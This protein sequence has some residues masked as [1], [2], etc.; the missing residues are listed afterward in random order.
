MNVV[1]KKKY[2]DNVF[3][4]WVNEIKAVLDVDEEE[5]DDELVEYIITRMEDEMSDWY[6]DYL[7]EKEEV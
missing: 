1:N 3:D 6:D 2:W 5:I 7:E 4:W